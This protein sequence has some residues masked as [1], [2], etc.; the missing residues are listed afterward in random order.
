MIVGLYGDYQP[1]PW[2]TVFGRVSNLLDRDYAT[3]GVYGEAAETLGDDYDG[4]YR[5]NGPG[6][7]RAFFG[8]VRLQF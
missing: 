8:G 6:A 3:F 2:L 4:E 1:A 5:F 7:P